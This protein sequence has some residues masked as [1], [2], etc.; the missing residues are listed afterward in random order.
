VKGRQRQWI[1]DHGEAGG[2]L[3]LGGRGREPER[4]EL[5][6]SVSC[7]RLRLTVFGAI[8]SYIKGTAVASSGEVKR[9]EY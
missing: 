6:A 3:R 5:V 7:L 9:E 8:I 1:L 2:W 4:Q